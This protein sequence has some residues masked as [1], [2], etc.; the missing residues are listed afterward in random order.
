MR[1]VS[2]QRFHFTED[3]LPTPATSDF[4]LAVCFPFSEW[5][6][7]LWVGSGEGKGELRLLQNTPRQSSKSYSHVPLFSFTASLHFSLNMRFASVALDIIL[8][9]LLQVAAKRSV[10]HVC[11]VFTKGKRV[12]RGRIASSSASFRWGWAEPNWGQEAGR[13][14]KWE[15]GTYGGLA[16][17]KAG[18][19]C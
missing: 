17:N 18:L 11:Q 3:P 19:E 8:T 4:S 14:S 7:A 13:V 10:W 6:L 5:E 16:L 9:K 12:S 1:K 2:A 15:G